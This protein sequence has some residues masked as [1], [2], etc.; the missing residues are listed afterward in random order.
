M[1]YF[2]DRLLIQL[3]DS[4]KCNIAPEHFAVVAQV[5]V[6]LEYE[7]AQIIAMLPVLSNL[8]VVVG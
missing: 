2:A 4:L 7:E 6:Q 8:I 3:D 1:G 5:D